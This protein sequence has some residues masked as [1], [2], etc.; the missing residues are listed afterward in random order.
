METMYV[1]GP[2]LWQTLPAYIKILLPSKTSKRKSEIGILVN[3]SAIYADPIS[4]HW[5]FYSLSFLILF[6]IVYIL[7]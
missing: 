4:H 1:I 6:V 3:V 2:Q 5:V 7:F